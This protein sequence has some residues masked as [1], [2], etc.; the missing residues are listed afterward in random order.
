VVS[1]RADLTDSTTTV[2]RWAAR[3][4]LIASASPALSSS[5]AAAFPGRCSPGTRVRIWDDV[6]AAPARF[7]TGRCVGS[8]PL[9]AAG[10]IE[11]GKSALHDPPP[12]A[13]ATPMPGAAHGKRRHDMPR[14]QP[15]PKGGRRSRDPRAHS[16]AAAAVARVRRPAG[17]SHPPTPRLLAS[18]SGSRRSDEPRAARPARRRPGDAY[19]R[20]WPHRWHYLRKKWTT[21]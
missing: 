18:R 15:A 9:C 10:L 2:T 14:S 16:P 7:A 12:L 13:Q 8:D 3:V 21:G 4:S 20:A 5:F 19:S 6:L 1:C 11:L 17:E